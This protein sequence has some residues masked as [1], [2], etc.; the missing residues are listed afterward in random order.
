MVSL[1]GFEIFI[2]NYLIIL[3]WLKGI[4]HQTVLAISWPYLFQLKGIIPELIKMKVEEKYNLLPL[5]L[6]LLFCLVLLHAGKSLSTI[7]L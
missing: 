1:Y 7:F 5:P 4:V 6:L 2:L 3:N